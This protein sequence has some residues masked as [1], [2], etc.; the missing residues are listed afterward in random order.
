MFIDKT[1]NQHYISVSEQK[2]NSSNPV[3]ND[4]E[5]IKIYSFDL[6]DREEHKISLSDQSEI[7]AIN[8]LSYLDLYTFELL[9]DGQRLCFEKLFKRLEDVVGQCT[10]TIL[11]NNTFTV[12]DFLNVFK[13]KLM[14]MIRNP[15]C[16]EFTLNNF[17]KLGESYPTNHELK[18]YYEKIERYVIPQ[19]ILSQ[20]NVSEAKY[21][22][23]LRTIFLMITPINDNK[24]ILDDW[25]ESFFNLDKYYHIINLCKFTNEVCLLSDR[26]YVNLSSLFKDSDGLSFGFNLRRDAFIY[27]S[28]LPN[29]LEKIAKDLLGP[30]AKNIVKFLK[31]KNIERIQSNLVV[32]SSVDNYDLLKNYNRHVIYQCA[33]NVYAAKENILI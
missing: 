31:D 8:N 16:I 4:R 21:K 15:F 18:Y 30:Q 25:A 23:W 9:D 14:N 26:S 5:K 27:I 17:G 20:F 33:H 3:N 24:Y 11:D 2:L 6:I 13:S 7:K 12:G 1:K 22:N 32:Q 19:R 28:F 29:D 10:N